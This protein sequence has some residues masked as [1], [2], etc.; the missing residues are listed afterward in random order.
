V[1]GA[2]SNVI[3]A[4]SAAFRAATLSVAIMEGSA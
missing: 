3:I 1:L 4:S 2:D